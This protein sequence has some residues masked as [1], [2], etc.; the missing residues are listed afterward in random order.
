MADIG[1]Y[2]GD[3]IWEDLSEEEKNE[4]TYNPEDGKYYKSLGIEMFGEDLDEGAGWDFVKG[5]AKNAGKEFKRTTKTALK[6]VA[7][8]IKN[9][10]KGSS[11]AKNIQAFKQVRQDK[12]NNNALSNLSKSKKL[13]PLFYGNNITKNN[14][15]TYNI[16]KD[17]EGHY[18]FDISDN[19]A[20]PLLNTLKTQGLEPAIII[21]NVEDRQTILKI[22]EKDFNKFLSKD[23]KLESLDNKYSLT[24]IVPIGRGRTTLETTTFNTL[25]EMKK[26][27]KD[28]SL[29]ESDIYS[30]MGINSI[31]DLKPFMKYVPAKYG[32]GY[33]SYLSFE[34]V[35]NGEVQDVAINCQLD[36]TY[37]FIYIYNKYK[38]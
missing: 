9:I 3:G 20:K 38:K 12:K 34:I 36:L 22:K 4:Y 37:S 6:G 2:P 11:T 16:P 18:V 23:I 1:L 7:S 24:E 27:F 14:D 5:L 35:E 26:Y 33:I 8:D 15:G 31:E 25:K 13:S 32:N 19:D 29:D 28:N 17:N 21:N 30:F 10:Y